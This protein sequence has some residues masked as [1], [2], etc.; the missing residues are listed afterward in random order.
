VTRPSD[1]RA[2]REIP[3]FDGETD[4]VVVGLGCAG[5][6]ATLEATRAGAEVVVL[7][8]ASGG[9]G[10]SA[11]SGG[12]IYLGGGTPIQTACG[13]EDSAED[14]FRYLMAACGPRPDEAKIRLYADESVEHYE[15]FVA[16]GVPFKPVFYPHYSGEPPTDDG[17]VYSGS[18]TCHP[19]CD[20]ARP[21]PRGHVPQIPGA[22]GG[23][24]MKTLIA[25]VE[26]TPAKVVT[27][28]RALTLVVD[29]AREVVGLVARIDGEERTIRARRGVVLTAGG[30]INNKAMVR[31]YAPLLTKCNFRVGAEG[32]DGAGIRMGMAV[33]AAAVN[34][35]LGS[36]SLPIFPP[37]SLKKGILVNGRGQRFINEDE[38]FGVLGEHALVHAGGVAYLV[39]DEA[40]FARPDVP[41]EIAGVG[42]TVE[43]LEQNL[44][45]PPGSLAATL[46]VYNRHAE[47]GEDPVF[48]KQ[49]E[50]IVPLKPPFGAL[51]CRTESSLYAAFTLGGLSTSVDGEVLTADAEAIPGLY[52]AGRTTACLAAPGYAS[53]IS[54]GDGTF[55]G[56]RAGRAAA[57]RRS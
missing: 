20:V 44:K 6:A 1:V 5:A 50:W 29:D 34:M 27:D 7:E 30:F 26:R 56:R 49:G 13:F 9:G 53:G 45:L 43:E 8:R 37:K 12:V 25:A 19:Y 33:G 35:S 14:M 24:L 47:H 52:A 21:A 10:T 4:V 46:A 32:D 23:F 22:A 41:R 55:F 54:I 57:A 3:R 48:R 36:V 40:T 15:W 18:E 39:L 42:D 17:L 51:D 16:H 28:A 31:A 2:L 11:M 38:Y